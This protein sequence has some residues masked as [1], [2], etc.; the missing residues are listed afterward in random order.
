MIVCSIPVSGRSGR[1]RSLNEKRAR[2]N[3]ERKWP[4]PV[5]SDFVHNLWNQSRGINSVKDNT[6][7]PVSGSSEHPG[8]S[9]PQRILEVLTHYP[10]SKSADVA[11]H[12]G[13]LNLRAVCDALTG[14]SRN[15]AV[16]RVKR[17]VYHYSIT[18]EHVRLMQKQEAGKRAAETEKPHK[19]ER[20]EELDKLRHCLEEKGWFSRAA[21]VCLEMVDTALTDAQRE[22]YVT[23]R[24]QYIRMARKKRPANEPA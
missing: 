20:L 22:K 17:G 5:C 16:T 3:R 12:L 13:E 9:L 10:D 24:S 18:P 23:L 4:H 14:L 1:Q 7:D 2:K 21:M 6:R 19:Q 11:R 15:G 8:M